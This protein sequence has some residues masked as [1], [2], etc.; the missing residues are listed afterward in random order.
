MFCIKLYL[1]ESER[2]ENTVFSK[3]TRFIR[4]PVTFWFLF[5]IFTPSFTANFCTSH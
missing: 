4:R 1:T 5:H 3:I 2:L